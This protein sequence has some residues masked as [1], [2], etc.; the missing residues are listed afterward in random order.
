[1]IKI[2][3]QRPSREVWTGLLLSVLIGT[4]G[5]GIKLFTKSP[6]ADPLLVSM[7]LGI[8]SASIL[9][10]H[11]NKLKGGFTLAPAIF[12]PVG[13]IFYGAHNL[14]FVKIAELEKNM[15]FLLI[16]VMIVYFTVILFLGR[17]LGQRKQITYL[18]ATGS[19]I[20]GASA[21]AVT[22]PA[23]DAEPDDVS[24]S[25]LSVALAALVGFSII[26]PFISSLLNITC[27]SH[28]LMSGSVLQFTGLVKISTSLTPF[29]LKKDLNSPDMISLALSVK[30]VRYLGLLIAIPL[31]ASLIKR[32]FYIPWFLWAFLAA[33]LIGTWIYVSNNG[34]YKSTLIPYIRPIH[35]VSWSIA[36]A[37]IG[38]NADFK[39][40][41]SNNGTKAILMAFAGFMAATLTFLI[42]FKFFT[43]F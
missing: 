21:I 7:V 33:G 38:L 42:G 30:A 17:I 25:L 5:Y 28:C 35:Y 2:G 36:M 18:T 27:R 4:L 10:E 31:F 22:S 9:G 19:A 29:L 6:I 1:L 37:A 39:E 11:D 26:I 3:T 14:N 12:I 40:L 32:K 8:I 20:C 41:L 13:I 43:Y 23:V 16:G 34:F 15:I 24:V